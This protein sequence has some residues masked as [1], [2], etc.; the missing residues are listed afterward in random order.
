MC[1]VFEC[2]DNIKKKIPSS[3]HVK[4][5]T[6]EKM[7]PIDHFLWPMATNTNGQLSKINEKNKK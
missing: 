7:Q 5:V 4:H 2:I 6:H 3:K 1:S